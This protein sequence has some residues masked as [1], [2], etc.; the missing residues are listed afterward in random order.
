VKTEV[1]SPDFRTEVA[2]WSIIR[3]AGGV[4]DRHLST[5][6]AEKRCLRLPSTLQGHG[7]RM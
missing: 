5:L 2:G 7:C 3:G 4:K 6:S 1:R